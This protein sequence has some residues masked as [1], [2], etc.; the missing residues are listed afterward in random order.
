MNEQQSALNKWQ[1]AN[2]VLRNE[3]LV[4]MVVDRLPPGDVHSSALT[5]KLF[6]QAA[7]QRTRETLDDIYRKLPENRGLVADLQSKHGAFYRSQEGMFKNQGDAKE[8][9]QSVS[10]ALLK[11]MGGEA[12]KSTVAQAIQHVAHMR[13]YPSVRDF[14]LREHMYSKSAALVRASNDYAD[15]LVPRRVRDQGTRPVSSLPRAWYHG[16]TSSPDPLASV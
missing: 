12:F 11:R 5:S 4:R 9:L 13:T 6:H 16:T 10:E 1:D 15:A 8:A 2:R 7:R 14:L 3:N